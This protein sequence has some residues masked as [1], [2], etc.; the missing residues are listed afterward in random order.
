MMRSYSER[1]K[2]NKIDEKWDWESK[3]LWKMYFVLHMLNVNY[4]WGSTSSHRQLGTSV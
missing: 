3:R 2:E 1:V 4:L